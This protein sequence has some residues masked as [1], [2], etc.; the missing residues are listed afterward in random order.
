MLSTQPTESQHVSVPVYSHGG[1]F[2]VRQLTEGTV[3]AGGG[4]HAHAEAEATATDTTTPAVQ[5]AIERYLHRHFPW[6][7]AV[8]IDR[9]WSGTMTFSPDGRPVVGP[10]S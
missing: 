10:D 7:Q 2:Y 6:T 5:A 9:R 1:E 8:P 3:L 4:R